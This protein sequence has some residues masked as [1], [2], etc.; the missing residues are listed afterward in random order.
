MAPQK[1]TPNGR[2]A[3]APKKPSGRKQPKKTAKKRA[4]PTENGFYIRSIRNAAGGSRM[5]LLDGTSIELK[6]RGQVGDTFRVEDE[7]RHDPYYL[8]N[9][10]LLFEELSL[11]D[12]TEVISKQ[13]TNAIA[14]RPSTMEGLTNEKGESY[15][16]GSRPVI[17]QPFEQQGFVAGHVST[18]GEGVHHREIGNIQRQAAQVSEVVGPPQVQVPG[19]QPVPGAMQMPDGLTETQALE[20]LQTPIEQRNDFLARIKGNEGEAADQIRSGLSVSMG[21]VERA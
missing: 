18:G 20:Y 14:P 1:V 7:I 10:G 15:P 4:A 13:G 9:L 8:A 16:A 19:S 12:G 6:P 2:G 21:P 5:T 17:E 11:E 3:S